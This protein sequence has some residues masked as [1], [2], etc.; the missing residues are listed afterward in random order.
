MRVLN[1]IGE[2]G[3][4]KSTLAAGV[5]YELKKAHV[6]CE[7]VTE[8]VKELIYEESNFLLS[9]ELLIFSEKYRR[10]KR[11][12]SVELALTD[13]SLIN[14]YFYDVEGHVSKEFYKN[15]AESFDNIYVYVRRNSPYISKGRLQSEMEATIVGKRILDYLEDKVYL[16]ITTDESS[17]AKVIT[18]LKENELLGRKLL[19]D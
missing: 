10:I 1:F 14:S 6:D 5:F 17:V 18:W 19:P 15:K 13:S 16:D 9:D 2:P 3:A 8:C 7:L 4:G 11:L 12:K